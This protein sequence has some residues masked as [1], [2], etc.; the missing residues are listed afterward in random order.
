MEMYE[1]FEYLDKMINKEYDKWKDL[2]N[3]KELERIIEFRK[4]WVPI[5]LNNGLDIDLCL[6]M[7]YYEPSVYELCLCFN[8]RLDLGETEEE[9][10]KLRLEAC[11]LLSKLWDEYN[12][13]NV[14]K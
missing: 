12:I 11:L 10:T 7:K 4:K 14:F 6:L 2:E 1:Y 8:P 9:S 3:S 5:S 13:Q